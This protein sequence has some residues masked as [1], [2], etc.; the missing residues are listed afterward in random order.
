MRVRAPTCLDARLR[1]RV[2]SFDHLYGANHAAMR[3]AGR[4]VNDLA[5]SA[6]G[7]GDG[8]HRLRVLPGLRQ[9]VHVRMVEPSRGAEFRGQDEPYEKGA[10]DAVVIGISQ[11]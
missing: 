9:A 10:G 2:A 7:R 5:L 3:L 6:I 4:R 11:L 8:S 1:S